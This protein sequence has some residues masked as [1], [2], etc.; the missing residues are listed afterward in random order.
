MSLDDWRGARSRPAL[1][2]RRP[3][4]ARAL[5]LCTMLLRA[6]WKTSCSLAIMKIAA[7]VLSRCD[8]EGMPVYSTSSVI[9]EHPKPDQR[10]PLHPV[11]ATRLHPIRETLT[12]RQGNPR[13]EPCWLAEARRRKLSPTE[14]L[15]PARA[16]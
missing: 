6:S 3:A 13:R 7:A 4:Q 9:G 15:R 8:G 1:Q 12:P 5:L 14:A 11:R 10:N 2:A 16:V